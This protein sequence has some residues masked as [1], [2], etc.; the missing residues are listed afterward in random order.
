[1]R[2]L[3]G[4]RDRDLQLA[5]QLMLTEVPNYDIVGTTRTAT[6]LLA[7]LKA[8]QVDLVILDHDLSD[9]QTPDFITKIKNCV[10]NPRVILIG[11]DDTSPQTDSEMRPD[12]F[13]SKYEPPD[14]F[15]TTIRRIFM[16]NIDKTENQVKEN[17]SS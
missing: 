17:S 8:S 14:R 4:I 7:L 2:I 3:L 1:M 11:M 9:K 6:G 12:A 5:L 10:S 13:V 15:V 16:E